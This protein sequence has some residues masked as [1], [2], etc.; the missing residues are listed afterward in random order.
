VDEEVT[1]VAT[2]QVDI[3]GHGWASPESAGSPEASGELA[4]LA[5]DLADVAE[6]AVRAAR[7]NAR[8][9]KLR[10]Q[11]RNSRALR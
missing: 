1:V 7:I 8:K 2:E 10:L 6:Q 4:E 5:E 3:A 9:G 11:R